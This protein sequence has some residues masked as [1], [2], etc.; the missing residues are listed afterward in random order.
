MSRYNSIIVILPLL[1]ALCIILAPL[2]IFGPYGYLWA[3]DINSAEWRAK[4]VVSNNGTAASAVSANFTSSTSEM[5]AAGMLNSDATDA[6][7]T[8]GGTDVAFMPGLGSNPWCVWVPEIDA[9]SMLN[10]YLYSGKVTGGKYAY[11]PGDGGMTISDNT[12]IE[13]PDNFTIELKDTWINTDNASGKYLFS[14]YDGV[15]GGIRCF[16]SPTVS[17]NITASIYTSNMSGGGYPTI[18]SQSDGKGTAAVVPV[19]MPAG[20][21]ADDLLIVVVNARDQAAAVQP[22]LTPPAGFTQLFY[23]GYGAET[24]IGAW[25]RVA[26]GTEDDPSNWT[27]DRNSFYSFQTIRIDKDS[28][29]GIPVVGVTATG[30]ASN[31][32]PPNLVSDFGAVETTWIAVAGSNLNQASAPAGYSNLLTDGANSSYIA[33]A[34]ANI[35]AAS[36]NPGTFGTASADW[37]ANTIAVKGPA[38]ASVSVSVTGVSS[39]EYTIEIT[40]EER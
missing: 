9:S 18:S 19:S 39:G 33:T 34:T 16:I 22:A 20:L 35:T 24:R 26:T 25:Y 15:N 13:S 6:A 14:H 30:A 2:A 21:V 11:F 29:G 38:G 12:T 7:I 28:Y 10:C 23:T 8:M 31:P 4:I 36:E 17:G 5:I 37:A 1:L 3:S 40:I 27:V 32:D